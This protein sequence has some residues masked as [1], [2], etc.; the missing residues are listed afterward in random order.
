MSTPSRP[1]V[2]G[3][4]DDHP[5]RLPDPYGS[6]G[7]A[8]LADILER[9]LDKGIVIAGDIKI[10]LLDIELL[11]IK[12]RLIV[13]SVD[14]AKEMGID[15]WENDP[16][17]SSGAHRGELARRT[18]SCDGVSR[19]LRGAR[20]WSPRRRSHVSVTSDELRYVYAVCRPLD[21][22]L[23]ADLTGVGGVPPRQLT[24][25][26][27]VALV[28]PVP[29]RDFAEDALR[30]H[31][32]DLDWLSETAR[33][34]QRVIGALTSVT[35]PLP[36]RL[37]RRL[38]GRQRG[39]RDAG[40][41]VRAVP[42]RPGTDGRLRGVGRQGPPGGRGLVGRDSYGK[43]TSAAAEPEKPLSGRVPGAC[44]A[45][46][47][48]PGRGLEAGRGLRPAAARG[49]LAGHADD[50][51]L[52]APQNSSLSGTPGRTHPERRVS[53]ARHALRGVRR[54]RGRYER[55]TTWPA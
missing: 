32:E 26:G 13:A 10:N 43:R 55:T 5:R 41:G 39:P 22:P 8:N 33:A 45:S 19:S 17:L 29:E 9:V 42:A 38:R 46:S 40:G 44:G 2:D 7:G 25:E 37:T 14:K 47:H 4:A 53:G 27:L 54:A 31:L 21:A 30:A 52:H 12:L 50:F 51:R 20:P 16:A 48:R 23:A 36:L 6:G 49:K 35:C 18:P 34:H 28:G 11:T 1:A 15:W 24:H 3:V